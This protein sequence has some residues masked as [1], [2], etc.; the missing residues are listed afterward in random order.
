MRSLFLLA[1]LFR[2]I[3]K[4][5]EK[6][7][8]AKVIGI[9]LGAIA[10]AAGTYFLLGKNANVVKARKQ[11]KSRGLKMKG[12]ILEKLED[13]QDV[14]EEKYV[15]VIDEVAKSY[16]AVKNIDSAELMASVSELKKHWKDIKKDLSPKAIKKA[17]KTA[18]KKVTKK[19]P[20][21]KVPAKKITKK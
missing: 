19:A 17:V 20:A 4:R 2:D 11:V 8:T 13:L 5:Y 7:N 9:G 3:M 15:S 21:K 18:V 10:A 1:F 16:K 12:E 6:K 14:T